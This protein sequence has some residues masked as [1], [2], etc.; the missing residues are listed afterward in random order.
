MS[1]APLT[2]KLGGVAGAHA[3]SVATLARRAVPGW[4]IVHGGGNEVAAWSRRLGHEPATIDG[5]RVTDP[6]TL[7]VAVAVLRGLA[8]ALLVARLGAAGVPAIGLGGAD[9]GLL[10]AERFEP[11]LGAVGRITRVDTALLNALAAAGLVP[12]VAPIAVSTDGELLNVNA[13]EVAGA[14][15]AARGGRLLLLTDVRGVL[16]GD[17]LVATLDAGEAEAM[18]ADGSASGGMIPKL[19]AALAAATAGCSVSIV[20][21]TDPAAVRDAL[22]GAMTGTTVTGAPVARAGST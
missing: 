6:P 5:L 13:D 17:R 16:R 2:V 1:E 7:D 4:V 14:I 21:G 10:I 15:A 8:N 9:G 18:L 12:V 3:S 20:D 11:R 19:R 22:D